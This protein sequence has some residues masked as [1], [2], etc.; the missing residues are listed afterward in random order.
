MQ[1]LFADIYAAAKA[2]QLPVETL[3]FEYGPAQ[4]ELTLHYRISDGRPMI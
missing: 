2:Q 3:I 1:P 4:Y